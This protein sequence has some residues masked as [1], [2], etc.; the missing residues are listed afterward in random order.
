M[1]GFGQGGHAQPR[2]GVGTAEPPGCRSC[3]CHLP[4]T[5]PGAVGRELNGNGRPGASFSRPINSHIPPPPKKKMRNKH[6]ETGRRGR[7]REKGGGG[8][9]KRDL[10]RRQLGREKGN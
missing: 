2:G 10:K 8:E 3:H 4:V 7:K 5:H 6:P 9:M 1:W